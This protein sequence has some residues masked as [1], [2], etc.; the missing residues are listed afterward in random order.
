MFGAVS[1]GGGESGDGGITVDD[2]GNIDL[3]DFDVAES[4]YSGSGT[5]TI[6][7]DGVSETIEDFRCVWTRDDGTTSIGT[8]GLWESGES[9]QFSI[10]T[11][12]SGIKMQLWERGREVDTGTW[13]FVDEPPAGD[14]FAGTYEMYATDQDRRMVDVDF[15]CVR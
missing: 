7:M 6:S 14:S 5:I 9:F 3:S 11:T 8:E 2:D 1:C 4:P 10:N 13:D 12:P 15:S